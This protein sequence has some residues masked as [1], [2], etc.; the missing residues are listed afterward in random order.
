MC[1]ARRPSSSTLPRTH[2]TSNTT[3]RASSGSRLRRQRRRRQPT[4]LP[5][6]RTQKRRRPNRCERRQRQRQRRSPRRPPRKTLAPSRKVVPQ[7]LRRAR[8]PIQPR[9][10]SA[11]RTRRTRQSQRVR[12][13]DYGS[14][15]RRPCL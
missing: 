7:W 12:W 1:P 4:G 14:N 10:V 2:S 15:A 5:S 3:R 11:T 13:M 8:A 9:S 6:R